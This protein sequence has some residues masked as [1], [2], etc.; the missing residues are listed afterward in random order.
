MQVLYYLHS[1][2]FMVIW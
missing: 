1:N 2:D